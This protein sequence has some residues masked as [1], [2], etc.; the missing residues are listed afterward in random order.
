M[1]KAYK[2]GDVISGTT[3]E[4]WLNGEKFAEIYGTQAKINFKK[5]EVP[6]CGTNNGSGQKMMGW[7]GTGSLRFNKV[8]SAL[9]KKELA[10]LKNG[11]PLVVDIVTKVKGSKGNERTHIP[12]CQFDDITIADWEANKIQQVEKPFTFNEMPE[13]LEEIR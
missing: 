1:V 11:E 6:M 5:E 9:L 7:D 2:P 4:A 12:S 3:G 13:L 8:N 10:A